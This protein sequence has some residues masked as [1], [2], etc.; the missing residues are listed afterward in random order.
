MEYLDETKVSLNVPMLSLDGSNWPMFK[1]KFKDYVEG[2]GI[3]T[4]FDIKNY[5]ASD[6]NK[7]KKKPNQGSQEPEADFKK[8]LT[9]WKEGEKEWKAEVLT[10]K[11]NDTRARSVFGRVIPNSMHME[12]SKRRD[13]TFYGMWTEVESWIKQITKHQRSNL[14]GILNQMKCSE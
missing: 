10:W 4:H 7:I 11:K 2:L 1:S 3:F 6:Y 14:K 13:R 5:P 9:V 8:R 12:I